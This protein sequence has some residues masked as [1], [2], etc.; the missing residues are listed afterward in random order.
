[1]ATRPAGMPPYFTPPNQLTRMIAKQTTPTIGVMNISSAGFMEMKVMETP[2]SAPS[3]AAL[4]VMR[5]TIGA[6]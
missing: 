2:A 3:S 1:M 4:G 5:R 6:R